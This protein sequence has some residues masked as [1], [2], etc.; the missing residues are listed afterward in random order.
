MSSEITRQSYSPERLLTERFFISS[1]FHPGQREIIE[2]L[3]RGQRVLA[4]LRTGWGKSLCYQMASLYYPHLTIVF[5]P[6]KALM[7][8]QCQRCNEVYAISSAILSSDF[9]TEENHATLERAIA[10]TLKLLFITPERLGDALWQRVVSTLRISM[11]V[12][13]EAH[14]I[15]S[16][17]HDFRLYYRRIIDSVAPLPDDTAVL[18]LTATANKR[19]EED[20][21]Q[22]IGPALVIRGAMY[23]PNLYLN[24]VRVFGDWEK[25]CYLEAVL[26]GRSDTGILYTA[27]QRDA[28]MAAT[29]L[30]ARGISAEYYHAGRDDAA[31]QRVEQGLMSNQYRVVCST[32]ALG[33]GIDK[34][35]VRFVIH[36]HLPASLIQYYQEIGRAGRDGNAA[37][38]I[39]L[40]DFT[41]VEIHEH[42]MQSAKPGEQQYKAVW[43]LLSQHHLGLD[44]HAMLLT[45]GLAQV[46]LRV[47]LTDLEQQRYITFDSTKRTYSL[48]KAS[49][50]TTQ[51][52]SFY[53]ALDFSA[54]EL[55]QIQKLQELQDIRAYVQTE[56]CYMKYVTSYLG[57]EHAGTCGV[58]GM[59]RRKH[60][61]LVRPS[62]RIQ[63]SAT[64]FLEQEYIPII[65]ECVINTTTVHEAGWALS[66]HGTSYIGKLVSLSKYE[67]GGPFALS[68]V[69]RVVEIVRTRYPM[70]TLQGVVHVPSTSGNTL[71]DVFAQQV[72]SM[73]GLT[74]LPVLTKKRT[75]HKQKRLVNRVQ[76]EA[77]VRGAFGVQ[78]ATAVVE[79]TLLLIDDIYDSGY[80]LREA[81]K[82]LLQAGATAVY[83][84]TITRTYHSD[85][86]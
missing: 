56:D 49:S 59:C 68:L 43:S 2:R 7:R 50:D 17:G 30:N 61:P 63:A 11:V 9:T 85:N 53:P 71:V 44:E 77:N 47:V 15:S 4:I 42:L 70:H 35:D 28:E 80:T 65:E 74:Y 57:D 78:P 10:G 69:V 60:F 41:D 38:C 32:T 66:Y 73:L 8:D 22:Q 55:V 23:R 27:T 21:L 45:T 46:I 84:M 64:H 33:M 76:K 72:A 13:D 24:V 62:E 81:G 86:Q 75:T 51:H 67:N 34:P 83:P 58:C 37:W 5:S 39:L 36:Y 52:E 29:F 31:R 6:L 14:C 48:H 25:L 18:A 19:V 26:Q 40:Y 54:R 12:I 20:I 79:R 16:W 3:V 1:G 82:T